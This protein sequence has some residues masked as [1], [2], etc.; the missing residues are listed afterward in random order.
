MLSLS[1]VWSKATFKPAL[2]HVTNLEAR[3]LEPE[4]KFFK[5]NLQ[6]MY[7]EYETQ[8]FNKSVKFNYIRSL[9]L[10]FTSI[11]VGLHP[12]LFL[13][14]ILFLLG[15]TNSLNLLSVSTQEVLVAKPAI[16]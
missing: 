8:F 2:L 15:F 14:R 13:D 10:T 4:S 7:L 1:K 6:S 3:N 16:S 9:F 12:N 5:H 11:K